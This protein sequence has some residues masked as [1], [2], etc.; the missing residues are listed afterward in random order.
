MKI[1]FDIYVC[2]IIH[3]GFVLDTE[4]LP[5]SYGN[6]TVGLINIEPISSAFE[7][8]ETSSQKQQ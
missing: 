8:Q 2:D 3:E 6:A 7:S 4:N 1:K 5:T